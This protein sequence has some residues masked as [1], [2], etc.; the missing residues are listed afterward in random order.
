MTPTAP[1]TRI[2][3]LV[4]GLALGALAVAA[5]VSEFWP[6]EGVQARPRPIR[7][8]AVGADLNISNP[9]PAETGDDDAW[10]GALESLERRVAAG[11]ER[12]R[13]SVLALEYKAAGAP[14]GARRVATGVVIDARGSVLSI[15]IDQPAEPSRSANDE[16]DDTNESEDEN[17]EPARI[18]ARDAFGRRHLAEW[19][20]DDPDTG[21]TLLRIPSGAPPPI[22]AAAE[23][24]ALGS[25]VFVVGNPFGLG[26]SVSRGRI[27]GLNRSL[28]LHSR[29]LNGLI[30][31]QTPLFPGDSGAVVA[32][33]RGRWL[34]LIRGG[35]APPSA[36]GDPARRGNDLGFAIP[37]EQALWI[38]SRLRDQGKVDRAY[39]GVRLE[40]DSDS[41][42]DAAP[43]REGA[44]LRGVLPDT[45]AARGGLQVGD[46][47]VSFDGQP[48]RSA[49][50]L[51]E[52][53]DRSPARARV[54]LEIVRNEET[55]RHRDAT[56]WI[57]TGSRP[58]P[59][60]PPVGSAL[61]VV[62]TA[63]TIVEPPRAAELQPT[64]P[65]AVLERLEQLEKR[66]ERL[67]G[68]APPGP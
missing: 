60:L 28:E 10:L 36:E 11:M 9:D 32:D 22:Q 42:A 17:E 1:S 59:I 68:A 64:L 20:A 66:I 53:L 57:E 37:A 41:E 62:S 5:A 26:Q 16:R 2:L 8:Q 46:R 18:V 24:P 58:E 49:L 47:I 52:R 43:E 67:E 35:L 51:T 30:Q 33:F 6:R 63:A 19:L 13:E 15:R 55:E 61:D 40:P 7:G 48:I 44:R 38:A 54:R 45:P 4:G 12:A 23:A 65:S 27:S 14:P 25:R 34:G 56:L 21:L 31:V 39:L 29:P 50:D 3:R